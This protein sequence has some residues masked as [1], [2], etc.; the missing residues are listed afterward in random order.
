M[1]IVEYSILQLCVHLP[2]KSSSFFFSYIVQK[3]GYKSFC[4]NVLLLLLLLSLFNVF[5]TSSISSS[6]TLLP[7]I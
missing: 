5:L 6:N 4:I 1:Y 3:E 7:S 2:R